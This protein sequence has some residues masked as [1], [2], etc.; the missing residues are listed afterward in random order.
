MAEIIEKRMEKT[1]FLNLVDQGFFLQYYIVMIPET[2]LFLNLILV[3]RGL[4]I[5]GFVVL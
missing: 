5:D 2:R 3:Q 1:D 4:I